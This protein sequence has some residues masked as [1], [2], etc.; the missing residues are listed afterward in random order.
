[1]KLIS[2]PMLNKSFQNHIPKYS[3]S[4]ITPDLSTGHVAG[5]FVY[6]YSETTTYPNTS[7]HYYHASYELNR[8]SFLFLASC[9]V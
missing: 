5:V 4:G 2:L 6:I 3:I 9:M 1:M 8:A 7:N